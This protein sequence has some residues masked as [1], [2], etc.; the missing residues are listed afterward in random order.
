MSKSDGTSVGTT[1]TQ[2]ASFVKYASLNEKGFFAALQDAGFP[3]MSRNPLA[4]FV[5]QGLVTSTSNN[6]N[7]NGGVGVM[8]DTF[9]QAI[10]TA[11]KTRKLFLCHA[12]TIN[13]TDGDEEEEDATV[14]LSLKGF[15]QMGVHFLGMSDDDHNGEAM[16][17]M[18]RA[19]I[20]TVP[21]ANSSS[22]RSLLVRSMLD[23]EAFAR[24]NKNK[25]GFMDES[26]L[27]AFSFAL[28][29]LCQVFNDVIA[30][31]N[32]NEEGLT[33]KTF[34]S[35]L[36]RIGVACLERTL[37]G[38]FMD[39]VYNR[40]DRDDS[41]SISFP[42]FVK[43]GMSLIYPVTHHSYICTI[44][45]YPGWSELAAA[46]A[47]CETTAQLV[48][49]LSS[50]NTGDIVLMQ[51]DKGAMGQFI[52][53]SLNTPWSHASVV[54]RRSP[55]CGQSPH[56]KTEELL[57][58]YPFRRTAHQFCS[59]GYCRCFDDTTGDFAPSKLTGLGHVGLLESTG[60]GIHLYDLAHRLFES[61]AKPWTSIAIARLH[62]A[63]GR[64]DTERINSF[65]Q[66]VRGGIYTVAKD[67]IKAAISY[68]KRDNSYSNSNDKLQDNDNSQDFPQGAR[69][70]DDFC[71]SIVQR[72][73]HH[74]GW[75]DQSR[76]FNSV[77]PS[78]FDV[79]AEAQTART[80]LGISIRTCPIELLEEKGWL[81]TLELVTCP[82]LNAQ[83][84][85]K[86]PK[87]K[88]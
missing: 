68:H 79:F 44:T 77:M 4:G 20:K 15:Q 30:E 63:P 2:Q 18:V 10:D 16:F 33:R 76:P 11:A 72:F 31:D 86:L 21:M 32:L 8:L 36:K 84:P 14:G 50:L 24:Y 58:A 1:N 82:D 26:E 45:G 3:D 75:V 43:A 35:A 54:V 28:V 9:E 64:D 70:S 61:G 53:F 34:S 80:G 51:D 47:T 17:P 67:E 46:P 52:N 83:L 25:T 88:K 38:Q 55:L 27:L 29:I 7:N 42:E 48:Q 13:S 62:N 6:N 74:M 22:M 57:R 65:I 5:F 81:G 49:R 73:Y 41:G 37:Q 12:I 39:S 56:Q 59:P 69:G 40:T 66:S 85:L 71:A 60:E 23:A 19:A 78:D 87:K